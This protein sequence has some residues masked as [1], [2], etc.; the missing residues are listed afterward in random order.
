M[1]N[2]RSRPL[3]VLAAIVAAFVMPGTAQADVVTDWFQTGR[4]AI[5]ASTPPPAPNAAMLSFA[6]LSGAMYDAANAVDGGHEPYLLENDP[7]SPLDS[8]NA[9]VATA[10]WR[11][12]NSIAPWSGATVNAK[13][14]TDIGLIPPGAAKTNG[15]A[16]G[17]AAA[18][19]ML[20]ARANDGRERVGQ[21]F[22]FVDP[23]VVGT[24][25]GQWRVSP[26]SAGTPAADPSWWVA[27][28]KP[29]VVRNMQM[30]ITD[31]PPALTSDQYTKD[32]NEVKSLGAFSNSTRTEYE[33]VGAMFWNVQ[34]IVLWSDIALDLSTRYGLSPAENARLLALVGLST[35]DAAIGAWINKYHWRFWRPIEAIRN[36]GSDGNPDTV[37]NPSWWP[38]FDQELLRALPGKP[39]SDLATA[40]L[41]TPPYPDVP[42]GHNSLGSAAMNAMRDFFGTDKPKGGVVAKSSRFPG[43]ER[44]F[45]RFTDVI[46]EIVSSRIW[47]GIHFRTADEQAA[48]LGKKVANWT[49]SHEL[50]PVHGH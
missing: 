44:R 6:V 8:M 29:F 10:A 14:A 39:Y 3:I 17:N 27:L 5:L 20:T 9:A 12:L 25:T 7:A 47:A 49:S 50:K 43:T 33:T 21:P 37:A 32:F 46:D 35:A 45:E 40:G 42:S 23:F 38:L 41:I 34:P 1:Q 19:A 18:D 22:P 16:A 36:A 13:Y 31:G 26:N 30:L 4:G 48:W 15:I 2:R 28:V 24:L 11:V